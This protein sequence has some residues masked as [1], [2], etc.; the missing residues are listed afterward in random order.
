[1]YLYAVEDMMSSLLA[2]LKRYAGSLQGVGAVVVLL[3][4]GVVSVG[5]VRKL[6]RAESQRRQ[7]RETKC[8]RSR[9]PRRRVDL[10]EAAICCQGGQECSDAC[11][12]GLAI[13]SRILR[14]VLPW[15]Y[16][17]HTTRSSLLRLA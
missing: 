10:P 3:R 13:G 2:L 6:R 8:G 15:P 16:D 17:R 12:E 4:G 5:R 1:M 9:A 14:Q 11:L 7:Q